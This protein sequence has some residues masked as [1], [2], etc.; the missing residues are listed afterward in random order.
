VFPIRVPSLSERL[1]DLPLLIE[2]FLA[3]LQRKLAKPLKSVT[4]ESLAR[5]QRYSWPGNIREL[6]NVL[7]RSCVLASEPEVEVTERFRMTAAMPSADLGP[8]TTLE[9]AERQHIRR[10]LESTKGKVDGPAGA[11]ALL[12]INPSTLRSRMQKL[13]I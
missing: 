2:H 13:G 1:D 6:Q 3:Q 10:A 7:E 5:M 8:M 9:E 12:G 4:P 11:A